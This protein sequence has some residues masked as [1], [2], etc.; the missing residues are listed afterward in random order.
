M[1]VYYDLDDTRLVVHQI[2]LI[3]E[4]WKPRINSLPPSYLWSAQIICRV[5]TF[6]FIVTTYYSKRV[7][8]PCP[9][10]ASHFLN[11][12]LYIIEHIS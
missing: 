6:C 4:G 5:A 7:K 10:D 12:M 8:S 2:T 9:L 1:R 3:M 11:P